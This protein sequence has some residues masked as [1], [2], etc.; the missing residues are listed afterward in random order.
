MTGLNDRMSTEM[1]RKNFVSGSLRASRPG[2]YG[3]A[4]LFVAAAIA[5]RWL[6]DYAFGPMPAFITFYPALMVA[7]LV[8]GLGPG[9]VA[10][11]LRGLAADYFFMAPTGSLMVESVG[12]W[13]ALVLFWCI[14]TFICIITDRMHAAWAERDLWESRAK[15][16]AALAAMTDAVFISDKE[17]RF[18]EFNDAFATFHRFANKEECAKT[19]A[20]YPDILDVFF[21]D[22]RIAPVDMWAVS[23]ALRGERVTNAE[24]TLRRKDTGE[25]WVGSYSF[26]PITR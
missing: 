3:L 13:V 4:L 5:A 8:G 22:G 23:R 16:D 9:L 15:F 21:S 24:Y 7:A 25:T 11:A 14:G 12:D 1:S 19:F 26:A 20:E 6:L 10:T 17:G 2:G 18:L